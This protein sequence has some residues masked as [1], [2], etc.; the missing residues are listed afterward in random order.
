MVRIANNVRKN[1]NPTFLP[2]LTE[3]PWD[4][5]SQHIPSGSAVSSQDQKKKK[6]GRGEEKQICVL[7]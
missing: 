6:K 5:V 7:T 1:A 3:I 2:S 4:V